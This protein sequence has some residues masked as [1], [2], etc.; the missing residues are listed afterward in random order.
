MVYKSSLFVLGPDH[1]FISFN[2]ATGKINWELM[3]PPVIGMA[4]KRGILVD[5]DKVFLNIGAKLFA[6]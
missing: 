1:R 4:P 6:L 3:L 2:A 5:K